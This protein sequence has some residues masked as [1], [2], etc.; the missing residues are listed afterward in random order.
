M[1]PRLQN[2]SSMC[3][4]GNHR[5]AGSRYWPGIVLILQTAYTYEGPP[6]SVYCEGVILYTQLWSMLYTSHHGRVQ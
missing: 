5:N 3:L 2:A 1:S 4:T 6:P